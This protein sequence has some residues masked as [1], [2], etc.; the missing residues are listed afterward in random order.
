ML[1]WARRYKSRF[2]EF[3]V[4]KLLV[5]RPSE[6]EKIVKAEKKSIAE[7]KGILEKMNQQWEEELIADVPG[8]VRKKVEGILSDWARRFRLAIPDD[9]KASLEAH[10]ARLVHDC[11]QAIGRTSG[12]IQ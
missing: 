10:I 4:P 1:T 9:A 11:T 12:G 6:D 3:V 2:F 8:T 7:I 5:G